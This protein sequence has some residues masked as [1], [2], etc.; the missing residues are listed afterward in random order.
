MRL[1][2]SLL[3]WAILMPALPILA[4]VPDARYRTVTPVEYGQIYG[5]TTDYSKL[6]LLILNPHK[7]EFSLMPD[8]SIKAPHGHFH[9]F[10]ASRPD[11]DFP[12]QE[13]K[14]LEAAQVALGGQPIFATATYQGRSRPVYL[15]WNMLL[16][17][18]GRP[19][20]PEDQWSRPVNLRDDTFIQFFV[21]VYLPRIFQP[22][23]K[24]YWLAVDNCS[25]LL[26]IYGVLDDNGVFHSVNKFDPPF[27]Q[28]DSDFLDSI[29]YFF[30]R[31]KE[32]APCVHIMGNEGT[33]SDESRF[34]EVW[35][36]FSGTYR[37]DILRSFGSDIYSR[38]DV[39]KEF[40]RYQWEGPAGKASLLRALLPNDATFNAKMY[41]SY[42][43]YLI[44]KGP[45]FFFGPR[46]SGNAN[47]VP[48]AAYAGLKDV[49]GVPTGA[50]GH[51]AYR[52]DQPGYQLYWRETNNGIVYLNWTGQSVTVT[53]P[54]WYTNRFGNLVNTLTIPDLTGDY[55]L[56]PS[57]N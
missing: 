27:A 26:G 54:G 14:D 4:G 25:F 47:A 42:I 35:A 32:V 9:H 48:T 31:L 55:V 6:G 19:T 24:N 44:M 49:L 53:L 46:Y 41:T 21:N 29:V 22:P 2:P 36:G 7:A 52:T 17:S 56:K 43:A 11:D 34:A 13:L 15:G 8:E 10:A 57:C 40:T 23:I 20:S 5:I 45:N 50:A 1:T 33:M 37:E 30:K 18:S 16:D 12:F 3:A 28:S 51:Q 39:Y 38:N